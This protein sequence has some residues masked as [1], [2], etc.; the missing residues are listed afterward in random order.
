ML[1]LTRKKDEAVVID[2]KVTVK[3]LEIH[4]DRVRLGFEAPQEIPVHRQEV[5]E[6]IDKGLV[7][8]LASEKPPCS[9]PCASEPAS[10]S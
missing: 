10:S 3:V 6:L 2:R 1:V 5:Q 7:P 4:A 8:D 9:S